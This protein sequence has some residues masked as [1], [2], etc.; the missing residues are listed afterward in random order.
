MVLVSPASLLYPY[1]LEHG[2][3][4]FPAED[5]G[6]LEELQRQEPFTLFEFTHRMACVSALTLTR[7]P[8]AP[9]SP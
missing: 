3:E 7:G 4:A 8:W 1:G 2:D 9:S 6:F 5:D